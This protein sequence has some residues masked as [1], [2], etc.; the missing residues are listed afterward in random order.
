MFWQTSYL[1]AAQDRWPLIMNGQY[2]AFNPRFSGNT[3]AGTMTSATIYANYANNNVGIGTTAPAATLHNAGSTI[4][5]A[6]TI[7]NRP[8]G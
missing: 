4:L 6:V 5:G 2:A 8:T 7:T 1:G 3:S